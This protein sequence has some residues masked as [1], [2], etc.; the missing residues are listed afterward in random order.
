MIRTFL[1]ASKGYGKAEDV[2]DEIRQALEEEFGEMEKEDGTL[3]T[4]DYNQQYAVT[5]IVSKV[6]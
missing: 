4:K 3:G 5:I 1:T 2:C 6:D